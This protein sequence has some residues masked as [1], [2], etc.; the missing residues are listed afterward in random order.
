MIE[1]A[2][3]LCFVS[4]IGLSV[5]L[6]R[7]RRQLGEAR[8]AREVLAT[9]PLVWF[10]GDAGRL[11]DDQCAYQE[12]LAGLTAE[13]A[14]KLEAARHRLQSVGAVFSVVV[15]TPGGGA[16]AVEG[17]RTSCGQTALWLV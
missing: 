11:E 14:T 17:R 4:L 6:L 1:F 3:T 2:I 12:F 7:A 10:G 9:V 16:C 5:L 15:A 8:S 13:D